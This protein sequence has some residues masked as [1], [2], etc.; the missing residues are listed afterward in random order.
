VG[1]SKLLANEDIIDNAV[2]SKKSVLALL[3]LF[4]VQGSAVV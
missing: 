4:V 1:G 2:K 3:E